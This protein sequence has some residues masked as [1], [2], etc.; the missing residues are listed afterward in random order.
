MARTLDIDGLP[1]GMTLTCEVYAMGGNT[2][3]ETITLTERTVAKTNYTGTIATASG[4]NYKLGIKSGSSFVGSATVYIGATDGLTYYTRPQANLVEVMGTDQTARD[5]GG[6]LDA[7]VS[8]RMA[9]YTQPTGFLSSTF[10]TTVASTTNITAG[11]I[12]TVTN[13][14]NA[15]TAGDLTATM[16]TSVTA[17]VPSV[18]AI[19]SGLSTLTA[20][21]VNTECDTAISDVGLTTTITGRIDDTISSR[22]SHTAADVWSVTTRSLTTFGSLVADTATA[23]WS[24]ATRTLTA[25][26]FT[27]TPSNAAETTAIKD[28][29]DN[30]PTDPADQSAVEGAITAAVS[31]L[32]TEANAASNRDTIMSAIAAMENI[33]TAEIMAAGDVDGFSLEESLKI[34]LAAL[35]GKLSGGQTTEVVIR[36]ADDSKPRITA[37]VD[38]SENRTAIT[39]DATG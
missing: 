27:P 30:L 26:G 15:A 6:N 12:T 28:K 3:V 38:S 25:F 35:A 14:T 7:A 21:Q 32:A 22:S 8:S 24:E 4:A 9:T 2:V 10:P 19:Q 29:T 36:A 16:K 17:A 11:T 34:A 37:T 1:S 23:I 33:S 20:A 5:L 31:G 18:D 39:L 13:L